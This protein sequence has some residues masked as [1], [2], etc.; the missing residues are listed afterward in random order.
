MCMLGVAMW[1]ICTC[2]GGVHKRQIPRPLPSLPA[3]VFQYS[4]APC[5]LSL[6]S[7]NK[8]LR[9]GVVV[10]HD[11]SLQGKQCRIKLRRGTYRKKPISIVSHLYFCV[12]S[13]KLA[14][15]GKAPATMPPPP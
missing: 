7:P 2:M 9:V 15:Q 3:Q 6:L 12:T 8:L 5:F 11:L 4:Y 13:T 14:Y 10:P 1:A